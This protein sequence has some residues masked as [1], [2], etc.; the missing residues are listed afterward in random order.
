VLLCYQLDVW[1]LRDGQVVVF[2]DPELTRM[3]AGTSAGSII[4]CKRSELPELAPSDCDP[5]WDQTSRCPLFSPE[6]CRK[7]PLLEEVFRAVPKETCFIIEFKQDSA[8]LI[9]E[10]HKLIKAADRY[11]TVLWFSLKEKVNKKLRAFDPKLPTL[12]SVDNMLK[13]VVA[14]YCGLMP[15]LPIQDKV[16][17]I[18]LDPVSAMST[19]AMLRIL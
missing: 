17:G 3:T 5:E 15:F 16:F 12:T 7:I 8:Q 6:E 14:Y 19:T 10:V 2:H 18:T 13:I 11:D 1:I 4:D 9:S